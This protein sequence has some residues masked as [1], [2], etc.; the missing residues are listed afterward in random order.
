MV[1]SSPSVPVLISFAVGGLPR[2][3][4]E[5]FS[6]DSSAPNE[7]SSVEYAAPQ[8]AENAVRDYEDMCSIDPSKE[9]VL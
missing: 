8:A 7:A 4:A 9:V 1:S 5:G 3:Q 2:W 6:I